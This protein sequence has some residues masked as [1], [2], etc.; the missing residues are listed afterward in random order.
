MNWPNT[1]RHD[2]PEYRTANAGAL[3]MEWPRIPLPGWPDG[4]VDS[5]AEGLAAAAERGRELAALLDSDAP[6]AGVTTGRLRPEL[7]AITVPMTARGGNRAGDDFAVSAGWG[8]FG[9]DDAVMPGQ[10]TI[11]ERDYTNDERTALS[12]AIP[13]LGDTTFDVHLN[14]RA[15]WRNVPASV[16]DHQLGGY[17]VLKKWLSYRESKRIASNQML[18]N[19]G[20]TSPLANPPAKL[21]NWTPSSEKPTVTHRQTRLGHP[22]PIVLRL[23]DTRGGSP[24]GHYVNRSVRE[25]RPQARQ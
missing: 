16:W 21:E 2:K 7:A 19:S 3:R 6:V 25:F 23:I 11:V 4:N 10:G 12:D 9:T 18:L 1:Y 8:H 22:S 13:M 20:R 17:Q 14:H 5:A 15:Y 24:K